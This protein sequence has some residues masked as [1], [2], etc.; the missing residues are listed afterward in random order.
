MR[1]TFRGV[2]FLMCG[3]RRNGGERHTSSTSGSTSIN[4]NFFLRIRVSIPVRSSRLER[5]EQLRALENGYKIRVVETEYESLGVDTPEDLERVSRV[6][7]HDGRATDTWGKVS[8]CRSTSLSRAEWFHRWA[9]GSR[10][11][12][13]GLPARE[14]R[15]CGHAAEVRSVPE[16]RSGHDESVS[17]RRSVRDR[18]RRGDR[19]RPRPLRTLHARAVD[20]GQQPDDRSDLR[21]D[22]RDASGAAIISARPCR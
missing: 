4:G 19:S 17:A 8:K 16:R 10:R 11:R 5:L 21:A 14:P 12:R 6:V 3:R 9:R 13:I 18:R 20:A 1:S 22:H 7:S 15:A 2:R